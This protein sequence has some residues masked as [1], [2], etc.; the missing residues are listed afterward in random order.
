[1]LFSVR[2]ALS[3][4]ILYSLIVVLKSVLRLRRLATNL[5]LRRT[6]F[7]HQSVNVEIFGGKNGIGIRFSPSTSLFFCQ[8]NCPVLIFISMLLITEGRMGEVVK[9]SPK[10]FP[11]RN[12]GEL[13]TKLLS[14]LVLKG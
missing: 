6:G 10:Q 1:M 14:P 2:H 13:L 8:Y 12:W 5:S 9:P 4:H 7:C 3:L 11:I